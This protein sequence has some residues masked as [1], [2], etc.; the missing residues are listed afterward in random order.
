[1]ELFAFLLQKENQYI[2][3]DEILE[4][5]WPE[6]A[7]EKAIKLLHTTIYNLKTD[8]KKTNV[9]FNLN[10]TNGF[11]FFDSQHFYS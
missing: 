7:M 3:R 11:Y 6:A 5:L 8:L 9:C 4:A 10:L 1:E 2:S